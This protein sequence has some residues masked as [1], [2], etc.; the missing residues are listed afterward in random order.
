MTP[1][2]DNSLLKR[3]DIKVDFKGRRF[4]QMIFLDIDQNEDVH[5]T[6]YETDILMAARELNLVSK[7][8]MTLNLRQPKSGR[9]YFD[10]ESFRHAR[11]NL[12]LGSAED[13]LLVSRLNKLQ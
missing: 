6:S 7:N 1:L 11:D 2:P 4:L 9:K 3:Y 12:G 10:G 13:A 8:I 5:C